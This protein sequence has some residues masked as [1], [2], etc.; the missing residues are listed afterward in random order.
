MQQAAKFGNGA[1]NKI[2]GMFRFLKG[3]TAFIPQ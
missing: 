3:F 2:Y 1:Q